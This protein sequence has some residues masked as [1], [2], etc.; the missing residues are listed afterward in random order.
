MNSTEC[1]RCGTCCKKGG[2]SF[3]IEERALIEDGFIPAK[4]LYTIREG[5]PVRDNMSERV[6][7]APSDIIKIKGQKTG[8]TC[9]FY[10]ETEKRCAV[11]EYRP[12]E[13]KLL[14]CRDTG[15]IERV[16]G[17]NLLTRKEIMGSVGGL[18]EL[19]VEHDK[20][21]SY[22]EIKKLADEP[23]NTKKRGLYPK[24]A[25]IIEYDK[26]VR[27][28]VVKK[29]QIDSELLDLLFGRPVSSI[30]NHFTETF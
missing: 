8:W 14:N 21:C 17:K 1:K 12:L 25:E 15:E 22:K 16:F 2:P 4:Y 13:C 9:F 10:D 5:E 27:E 3:H 19:I 6:V 24:I 29:G 30:I 23:G 18:W 26:T 28:L 20:R 7:Y 11:Y